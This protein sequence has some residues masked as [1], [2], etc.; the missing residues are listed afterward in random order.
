MQENPQ[1]LY[2]ETLYS[3]L[4]PKPYRYGSD[5]LEDDTFMSDCL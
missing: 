5:S 4:S 2:T 3:L 1:L